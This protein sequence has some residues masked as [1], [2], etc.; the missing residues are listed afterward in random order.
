M[1]GCEQVDLMVDFVILLIIVVIFELLGIF[2]V[3]CEYVCQFWE[4]QV[5]LLLLEEVQVLVD[6][7]VDYLC[8]L[9]EVKC[10]QLVDDVYSGLVQVVDESGQLS[11]VE[12][13]FMVYLLMMSGFEIIMNMI[14]N[15]LVILLVNL[16]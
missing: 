4:C 16:E 12:F 13:V 1:V 11:E 6:V 8:V 3:E 5:E 7:Q 9:F 15:V 14:G 10:W 2:E